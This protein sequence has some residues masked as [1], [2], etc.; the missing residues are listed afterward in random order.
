MG[1]ADV[2]VTAGTGASADASTTGG[3][4]IAVWTGDAGGTGTMRRPGISIGGG[5][6]VALAGNGSGAASSGDESG[7]D[8]GGC[9]ATG[10]L[11]VNR[12][13]QDSGERSV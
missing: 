8:E 3:G 2:L 12:A 6:A 4:A 11:P 7:D 9:C 10:V 1:R 5:V 13:T